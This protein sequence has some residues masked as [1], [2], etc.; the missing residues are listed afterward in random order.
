MAAFAAT[1][2]A[3]ALAPSIGQLIPARLLQEISGPAQTVLVYAIIRD[4]FS[5]AERIPAMAIFGLV[6]GASPA[7]APLIG[8]HVH[9]NL[10]GCANFFLLAMVAFV[11]FLL[12][13]RFLL[14]SSAPDQHARELREVGRSYLGLLRDPAFVGYA[15]LTETSPAPCLRF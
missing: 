5:G 12:S 8:D 14:E 4:L 2:P 7:A 13:D 9:V 3:C 1:S 6:F 11:A 15:V 10:G